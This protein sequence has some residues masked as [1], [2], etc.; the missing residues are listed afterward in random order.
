MLKTTSKRVA[1][2]VV[3]VMISLSW[4]H[5]GRTSA[6]CLV[7]RGIDPLDVLK[8]EVKHNVWIGLDNSGSMGAAV[9]GDPLGRN[10]LDVAKDVLE[11]V[12][13]GVGD[14]VNW[15]FFYTVAQSATRPGPSD[16]G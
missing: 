1:L 3:A 14:A 7:K 15:G 2:L 5:S 10:R 9:P 6:A 12:I 13:N 4:I 16:V 8:L 11:E